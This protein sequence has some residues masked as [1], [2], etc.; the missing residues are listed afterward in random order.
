MP[1][2]CSYKKSVC[3]LCSE[4]HPTKFRASKMYCEIA[5]PRFPINEKKNKSAPQNQHTTTNH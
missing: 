4:P 5:K 3:A 2:Q 1:E